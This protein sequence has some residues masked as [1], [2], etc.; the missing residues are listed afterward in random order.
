M[1]SEIK[2]KI[3]ELINLIN[4]LNIHKDRKEELKLC[5]FEIERMYQ[6][7]VNKMI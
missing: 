1:T 6:K 2:R 4:G 5:I 7:E 3:T